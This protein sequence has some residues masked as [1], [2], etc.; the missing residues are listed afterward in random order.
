VNEAYQNLVDC[1]PVIRAAGVSGFVLEHLEG[2]LEH[3]RYAMFQ[4]YAWTANLRTYYCCGSALYVGL[5]TIGIALTIFDGQL[6]VSDFVKIF[7]LIKSMTTPI[8][9]LASFIKMV[10]N[11]AGSVQLVDQF[12]LSPS[13]EEEERAGCPKLP[14]LEKTVAFEQVQFRYAPEAPLVLRDV[15]AEIR[16]PAYVVMCGGSGSGKSTLLSLLMQFRACT[17]GAIRL[18]GMDLTACSLE[19]FKSQLGVVFQNT[20]ILNATVAENIAFGTG[21]SEAE[22]IDAAKKAEVDGIIQSLPG[23][24]QT[25]IGPSAKAKLS[26]GQMQRICLA[27]ALCRQPRILL[28]D[29]ATSALDPQ[30]EKSVIETLEKLR[31]DF[32]YTILSV[33]HHPNTALH[34][35]MILLLEKGVL[36]EVGTYSELMRAQAPQAPRGLFKNLVEQAA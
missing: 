3:C 13:M 21:A 18:D 35:D 32:G 24:Y 1:Q 17:G 22:V 16:T 36:A 8:S 6:S 10:V 29:E 19:S 34:A 28:L 15:S 11:S 20:M 7:G 33:S 5:T 23:R 4:L 12:L 14:P 27:R 26:G 30:T 25:P 2:R 31:R 9:L